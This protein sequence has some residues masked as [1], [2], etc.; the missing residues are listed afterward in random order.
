MSELELLRGA[1]QAVGEGLISAQDYD[2]VKVA[3]LRAQQI[4][5]GLDA[6]FIRSEDYD[7][8]RDAY[9]NA[10][11]FSIMSTLPTAGGPVSSLHATGSYDNVCAPS[12]TAPAAAANGSGGWAAPPAAA[13]PAAA[14]AAPSRS[15]LPS[16]SMGS[17]LPGSGNATPA[18]IS[19]DGGSRNMSGGGSSVGAGGRHSGAPDVAAIMGDVPQYSKGA[20][21]GKV[22][23]AGIAINED[24]VNLFMHMK[25]RSAVS[26]VMR[27]CGWLVV[28]VSV[29]S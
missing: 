1:R 25:A 15:R 29:G 20:T 14:A 5:A 24:C 18:S 17:S 22:S 11:D 4:K 16:Q 10:L 26:H 6:G 23:M 12:S 21:A 13:P 28:S 19:G 7:K 8:A 3:F 27:R 9:L 2:V